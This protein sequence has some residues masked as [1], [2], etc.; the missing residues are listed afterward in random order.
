MPFGKIIRPC[1]PLPAP[2]L[3]RHAPARLHFNACHFFACFVRRNIHGSARR[4]IRRYP[5]SATRGFAVLR[6]ILFIVLNRG[7]GC[8]V[9]EIWDIR[10]SSC[11]SCY[12]IILASYLN[13]AWIIKWIEKIYNDIWQ[14]I[15]KYLSVF[16]FMSLNSFV[17]KFFSKKFIVQLY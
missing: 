4:E 3:C 13:R 7:Y 10:L 9:A 2:I 1:L 15:I 11:R 6:R 8:T 12:S 16:E 14:T 17:C 5:K